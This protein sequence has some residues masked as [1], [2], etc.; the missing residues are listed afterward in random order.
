MVL[1]PPITRIRPVRLVLVVR[2][3]AGNVKP[4]R[5][6]TLEQTKPDSPDTLRRRISPEDT[7]KPRSELLQ[8]EINVDRLQAA[9]CVAFVKRH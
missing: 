9:L 1:F 3:C 8:S 6:I 7:E 4:T 5:T 2:F